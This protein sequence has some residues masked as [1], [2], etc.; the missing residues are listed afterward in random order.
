M[1]A[2]LCKIMITPVVI[3]FNFSKYLEAEF[4]FLVSLEVGHSAL[5]NFI[6]FIQTINENDI[7]RN[8]NTTYK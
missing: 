6:L 4:I 7:K 1:L 2:W 3:K 5:F 8:K